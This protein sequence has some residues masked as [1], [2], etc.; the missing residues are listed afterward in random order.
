MEKCPGSSEG[1]DGLHEKQRA[2]FMPNKRAI[3]CSRLS[4]RGGLLV[5]F[6]VPTHKHAK[7]QGCG[8]WTADQEAEADGE[9]EKCRLK[10]AQSGHTAWGRAG[11]RIPGCCRK[12]VMQRRVPDALSK[13]PQ[14][15]K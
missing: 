15:S 6:K 8:L 5:E 11:P 13:L 10:T 14:T 2:I 3:T 9:T 1:R 12:P 7:E 4:L